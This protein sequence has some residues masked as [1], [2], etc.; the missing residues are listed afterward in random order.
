[1]MEKRFVYGG[2]LIVKKALLGIEKGS[3]T[4]WHSVEAILDVVLTYILET[5]DRITLKKRK[6]Q[7][8]DK[9]KPE[10]NNWKYN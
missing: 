3:Y 1:M 8:N 6:H 4:T 9:D 5:Q 2:W 10:R 7:I